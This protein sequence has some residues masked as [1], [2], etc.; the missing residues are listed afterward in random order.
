M[1]ARVCVFGSA[2]APK[3]ATR[4]GVELERST[5]AE[6]VGGASALLQPLVEATRKHVMAAEKPYAD[7]TPFPVLAPGT[8]KTK[9]G[10]L[11]T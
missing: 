11:W 4:Q 6:W 10:R 7:D 1:T 3:I 9:T 8:G 2:E 5:L